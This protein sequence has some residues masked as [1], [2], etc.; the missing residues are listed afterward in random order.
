MESALAAYEKDLFPR[1]RS[2]AAELAHNLRLFFNDESPQSVVD[3]FNS[4][5]LIDP[6]T[7]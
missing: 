4:H 3:L 5:L 1:S 6:S 2:A 7:D